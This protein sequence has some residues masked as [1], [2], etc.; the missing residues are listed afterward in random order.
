VISVGVN[1]VLTVSS[2][3]VRVLTGIKIK[4]PT[5]RRTPTVRRIPYIIDI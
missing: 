1:S 4:P 3:V 2:F 5:Q